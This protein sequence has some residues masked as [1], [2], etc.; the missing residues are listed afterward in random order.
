MVNWSLVNHFSPSEFPDDP[1][2]NLEQEVVLALDAYRKRLGKRIFPSKAP[3][4]VA[5]FDGSKT[6]QHYAVGRRSS[7]IDFFCE[8]VPISNLFTL[9][10]MK[11]FTRIGVY[12]DTNG[13]D[14]LPW[15]MF[16]ADLKPPTPGM[17]TMWITEKVGGKNKYRYPQK[18]QEYWKLL[19]D[20]RM[21]IPREF[22]V[23]FR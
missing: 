1:D 14:G 17:S 7:A 10:E 13:N 21:Y 2:Q 23:D 6:S 4:A 18:L 5:R 11:V 16:H 20:P 8:G 9:V 19:S 3:G 12:L 22:I 15:V